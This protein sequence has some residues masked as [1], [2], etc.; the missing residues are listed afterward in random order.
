MW[1]GWDLN[2]QLLW[3]PYRSCA[4]YLLQFFAPDHSICG[5]E[6]RAAPVV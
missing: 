4:V 1:N 2:I 5:K 6:N 3:Q